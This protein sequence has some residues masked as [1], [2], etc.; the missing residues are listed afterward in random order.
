MPLFEIGDDELIP[1]RRVHAGPELYEQEIEGLLWANL[2]S[3]IGVQLFPLAR[4][5]T[6]GDGIR[7]DIVALDAE[8]HVHVIE[9][10]RDIDRRQ[11]A[12]CLEYAG[13]ARNAV[14]LTFVWVG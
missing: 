9:V 8:G 5:P 3:F 13:W 1:F 12:Q 7:P 10:K 2:D 6:V 14:L 11:L 4:Q